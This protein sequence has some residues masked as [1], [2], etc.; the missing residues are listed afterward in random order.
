MA[1]VQ[2]SKIQLRRGKKNSQSGI[3][4]L[5]SAEMA[6]A[7]DTQELFIGNGSVADGAPYVGN[8]KILTE[9]DNI[10][11]FVASYRFGNDN[12]SIV[13]TVN[14][15][16]QQKVDEIEVSVTDY[17][18]IDDGST[19]TTFAFNSAIQ[20]LFLNAD[21]RLRKVLKIPNGKYLLLNDL[22][23]PSNTIIRGETRDESEIIFG[24]STVR[25]L[26]DLGQA[27]ID[28]TSTNRPENIEFSNLT[29]TRNQGQIDLTGVGGSRF[30][31]VTFRGGYELTDGAITDYTTQTAALFWQNTALGTA[32][33]GI[34]FEGCDF[35]TNK[36]SVKAVQTANFRTDVKFTGCRFAVNGVGIYVDGVAEQSND[37]IIDDCVFEEIFA[38]ALEFK[39]GINTVIRDCE[40]RNCANGLQSANSPLYHM[41]KFGQSKN[42]QIFDSRSNRQQAAGIVTSANRVSIGEVLN[43]DFTNFVD[44]VTA[45]IIKSDSFRPMAV[46]SATNRY[47]KI[48]YNLRLGDYSR[49]GI[50]T[51]TID[52]D[53]N[54]ANT[55]DEYN[56]SDLTPTSSGGT[57]MTNFVFSTELRDNNSDGI[58]ETVV[59]FYKNPILTGAA[60]EVSFNVTYGV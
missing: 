4:Q 14:R 10:L 15:P 50:L 45:P 17:G 59:V 52:D 54:I 48:D 29:I 53:K 41:V 44:R 18:A 16:L 33:T 35:L 37:W 19:D 30:V 3:P 38:E 49:F 24:D 34:R 51:I 28:F 60:G 55:T 43:S 23:I 46:F 26:N 13:N 22:E 6:W 31:D 56:Y 11:S 57:I 58:I 32:T 47:V 5:S 7:V 42:N 12:F 36:L 2:I 8:T 25:F 39:Q 9:H 21:S 40:F 1:V 27:E 20:E